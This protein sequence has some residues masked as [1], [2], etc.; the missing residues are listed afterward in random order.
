MSATAVVESWNSWTLFQ[1][2]P[3]KSRHRQTDQQRLVDVEERL[4]GLLIGGE[5]RVRVAERWRRRFADARGMSPVV[6]ALAG[7]MPFASMKSMS[8]SRDGPGA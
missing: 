1:P 6:N 2:N 7:S 5:H 3:P 8:D 4:H